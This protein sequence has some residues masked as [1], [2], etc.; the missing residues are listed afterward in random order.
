MEQFNSYL[1]S[2]QLAETTIKNHIRNLSKVDLNLLDGDEGALIRYVQEH[3]TIGSQQKTIVTS[4]SKYRN[5]KNLHRDKIMT[6]LT[7]A[8]NDSAKIQLKNNE[9]RIIPDINDVKS[10]MNTYYKNGRWRKYAI[11][12]LLIHLQTRNLD[13]VAKVTSD[14]KDIDDE[15]NWLYV[16]KN[17]VVFIRNNYKTKSCYGTKKDVI[18]N[19]KFY[20]SIL[21]CTELL[22]P[23]ENLYRSV[24]EITGN[25]NETTL[26]KMA[27]CNNNNVKGIA[28][29]SKNR[30]T[31]MSV[32]ATNYDCT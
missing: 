19:K 24:M 8:N 6:L 7:K 9:E 17:D 21:L 18:V 23:N 32:I 31:S 22:R 2:N 5:Y 28:K 20:N 27:V 3:Y 16:R 12:Y 1:V 26:M 11:M 14:K 30:G 4:I 25:I 29:I 13:L 10:L 15:T